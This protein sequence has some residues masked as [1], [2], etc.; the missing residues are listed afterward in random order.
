MGGARN[1]VHQVSVHKP[2]LSI[3]GIFILAVIT[4][5][6]MLYYCVY[7]KFPRLSTRT[8]A[9]ASEDNQTKPLTLVSNLTLNAGIHD[10]YGW[11]S[12]VGRLRKPLV[13]PSVT[14][15]IA[16]TDQ[17]QIQM[18][19]GI[20]EQGLPVEEVQSPVMP[21][22]PFQCESEIERQAK[23]PLYQTFKSAEDKE[24]KLRPFGKI[25]KED[26]QKLFSASKSD[27]N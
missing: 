14:K 19:S 15:V 9:I 1:D 6:L 27:K 4:V 26:Q 21:I 24:A 11:D 22:V 5:C 12:R 2:S 10:I 18:Q 17:T 8:A 7:R 25:L 3:L 13:P 16:D 20:E 23:E